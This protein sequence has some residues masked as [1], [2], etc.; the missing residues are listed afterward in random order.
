[1]LKLDSR[2]ALITGGASGIGAAVAQRFAAEGAAVYLADL[3]GQA[4]AAEEV[5]ASIEASGGRAAFGVLDVT[6]EEQVTVAFED[7]ERRFGVVDVL[8]T[9]AGV[10]SHP[11]VKTRTPLAELPIEHWDFVMDI[12]LMGTFLCARAFARRLTGAGRSGAIVTLA[13]LA[14]KK[15]KGGVYS[16]SKAGV[17]MLT[18]VL[19]EELGPQGIRANSIAPGLIETPMLRRRTELAGG[20]HA[21]GAGPQEFYAVDLARLPLRRIGTVDEVASTALFLASDDSSYITGSIVSPDGGFAS[22]SAGG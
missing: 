19:A 11:A 16:V 15:P 22:S 18:R 8:V 17:W 21:A 13:S 5:V 7:A 3:P 10:D 20:V 6:V 2:V 12:N 1:V 14:A 9:S 4:G